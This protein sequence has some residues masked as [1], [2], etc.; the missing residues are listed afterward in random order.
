M[1]T[2]CMA[3][4]EDLPSWYQKYP[5]SGYF[6]GS[7]RLERRLGSKARDRGHLELDDLVEVA[8]WG[9]NLYGIQVIVQRKNTFADIRART[10]ENIERLDDPAAAL[11]SLLKIRR[12]GLAHA[13]K[14]LRFICPSK[15]GRLILKYVKLLIEGSCLESTT[16]IHAPW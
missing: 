9:G 10:A 11:E 2:A 14:T 4:G 8:N 12:W 3:F 1:S 15:Y 5:Q 16:A 6:K 7:L 13:S